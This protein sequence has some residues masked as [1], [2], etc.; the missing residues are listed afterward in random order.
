MEKTPSNK[1]INTFE[2]YEYGDLGGWHIKST[3]FTRF[4][5]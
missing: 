4:L 1:A 2:K 5:N 3:L